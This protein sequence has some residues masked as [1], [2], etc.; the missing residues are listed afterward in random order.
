MIKKDICSRIIE[1][2]LIALVFIA[3]LVFMKALHPEL[4][5]AVAIGVIV[6]TLFTVWVAR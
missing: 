2:G 3:P 6:W 1:Y 4:P 5:K